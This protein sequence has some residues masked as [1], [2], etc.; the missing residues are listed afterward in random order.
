MAKL[1]HRLQGDFDHF[2]RYIDQGIISGSVSASFE[3]GSDWQQGSLSITLAGEGRSLFLSAI[4]SGGSQAVFFKIN[5]FG[6]QSF[7]DKLDQL[8]SAYQG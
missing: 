2:L 5:R 4:T 7:L 1:E 8:V 6:E 3:D